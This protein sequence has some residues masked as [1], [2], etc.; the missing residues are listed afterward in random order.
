MNKKYDSD[1][2]LDDSDICRS[3]ITYAAIIGTHRT[4]TPQEIDYSQYFIEKMYLKM[5]VYISSIKFHD[6]I[7]TLKVHAKPS[8]AP[9]EIVNQFKILSSK[10]LN[11]DFHEM[12]SQYLFYWFDDHFITT[13]LLTINDMDD[14]RAARIV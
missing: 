11:E 4:I 5:G 8:I 7:A 12:D 6:C 1:D 14:F 9:L 10:K 2:I 3:D 13:K